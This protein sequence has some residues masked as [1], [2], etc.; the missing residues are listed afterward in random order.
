MSV[1]GSF[2]LA[3]YSLLNDDDSNRNHWMVHR[4]VPL[5][6]GQGNIVRWYGS[7]LDIEDRKFRAR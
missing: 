7:S 4:K 5:C 6:D 1:L 2:F 3:F